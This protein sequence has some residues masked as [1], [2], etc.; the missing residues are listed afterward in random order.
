MALKKSS[1][2]APGAAA[3]AAAGDLDRDRR[4][5]LRGEER[6]DLDP[7]RVCFGEGIF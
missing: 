6:G 7:L 3:A 4:V 5:P 1:F 2:R